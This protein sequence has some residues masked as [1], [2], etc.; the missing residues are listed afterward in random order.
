VKP[1]SRTARGTALHR[2]AHQ[3]LEAGA[4][5]TDP[6]AVAVL[7]EE[8]STIA[9]Q[10]DAR[11][12]RRLMRLFIA[13]RSRFADDA[14]AAAYVRG[15]RQVVVLGAGLDTFALRNPHADLRVF[16]VDHPSTQL[17]K[18]GQL[19]QARLVAPQTLE[20]VPVDFE[21]DALR[22]RLRA[23]GFDA[24]L[25]AFFSWLGVVPYLT[26]GAIE[27]TLRLIAE[28]PG[29]EVVFDYSEPLERYSAE[30]RGRAEELASR[31]AAAGEPFVTFFERE[32][33][34]ALLGNAGFSDIEDLGAADISARYFGVRREDAPRRHGP[35]LL[36]A[37]RV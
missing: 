22:D 10:E 7:G 32:D 8:A 36:R 35:H 34:H 20:F 23:H 9:A 31:V 12:E 28:V 25:P 21:S 2:A 24:N 5:F 33:L 29:G 3:V 11:P 26:R 15:T 6:F 17:W 4:I 1:A 19:A 18:R 14:A 30:A 13:S 27:D 37:R 16:E